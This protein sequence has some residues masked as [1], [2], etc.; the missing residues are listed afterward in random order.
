MCPSQFLPLHY[1]P[2]AALFVMSTKGSAIPASPSLG[3][4]LP[5]KFVTLGTWRLRAL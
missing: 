1:V 5:V 2:A 4:A 3:S